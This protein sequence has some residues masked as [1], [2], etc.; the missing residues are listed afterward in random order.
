MK[1]ISK[2]V[3]GFTLTEMIV[4]IAIIGILAAILAP[5]MTGYYWKSRV[6][7]ANSDARMVYNAAQTTAQKF[8]AADRLNSTAASK[9]G[10]QSTLIVSYQNGHFQYKTNDNMAEAFISNLTV[11][12]DHDNAIEAS[13]A[14]IVRDVNRTVS[15]ASEKCWTIY[16]H[17][18]IVT[19]SIA[20]DSATTNYVG[21][22]SAGKAAADERSHIPYSSWVTGTLNSSDGINSLL[23][24]AGEYH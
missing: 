12:G 22:C 2:R 16:I 21:Y 14:R 15:G 13:A 5:T 11:E 8:L 18:Y 17:N 19:G 10:L 4:V 20:A 6:K 23:D 24:V 3:K 1:T 7:T 9:S